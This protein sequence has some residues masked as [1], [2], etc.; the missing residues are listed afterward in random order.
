MSFEFQE[1]HGWMVGQVFKL[2]ADTTNTHRPILKAGT[3]VKVVMCSRFG[4]CGITE[5]LKADGNSCRGGGYT[6][7]VLPWDLEE[8]EGVEYKRT[9]EPPTGIMATIYGTGVCKQMRIEE[10]REEAEKD[11]WMWESHPKGKSKEE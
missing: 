6:H 7:R 10:L 11:K 1:P 3:H 2:K 4:D 9:V 8:L 5:D